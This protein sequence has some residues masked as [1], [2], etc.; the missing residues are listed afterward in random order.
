MFA[1]AAFTGARR[2]E[3]LRSEIDDFHLDDKYVLIREKKRR[4]AVRES[5]R[6]VQL[7][8]R[9]RQIMQDW[10]ANHPG[11]H[12]T[13]CIKPDQA[14]SRDAAHHHFSKTLKDCKWS[15]L[16][17]FHV[18]RHSFASIC[19]LRGVPEGVVDAWMGHQTSEMRARYRHLFP[20][21][22]QAAMGSLF[23]RC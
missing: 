12:R 3:I 11:G 8:S 18:L 10:F 7:N 23:T 14:I 13:L 20:E 19:A 2:S 15:K 6:Q 21:Q 17:G 22:T 16:R 1:F 9:L 4:R 5:F